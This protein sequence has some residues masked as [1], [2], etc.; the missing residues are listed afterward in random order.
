MCIRTKIIDFLKRDILEDFNVEISENDQLLT[1][2]IINS[3][4]LMRL[5]RFLE[6]ESNFT[7]PFEDITPDNFMTV[8]SMVNYIEKVKS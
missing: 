4:G 7:I 6:K 1:S 5:V 8:N 2:G 3:L